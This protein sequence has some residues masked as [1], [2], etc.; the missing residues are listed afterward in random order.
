VQESVKAGADLTLFSGDKLLGGP[1]AGVI[2]GRRALVDDLRRHPLARAVRMDKATI[3]GLN[4][5]LLHYLRG[6]ALE[7][8]PVWRMIAMTLKEIE[9]RAARWTRTVGASTKLI[10]GRSVV[11]GNLPGS[12]P[13][14]LLAIPGRGPPC[15]DSPSPA[16]AT[17]RRRAHRGRPPA[18]DPRTVHPDGCGVAEPSDRPA[19]ERSPRVDPR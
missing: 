4:A 7:K 17:R 6:E 15:R 5:T 12:L 18:L 19:R 3:A 8:V 11:G 16:R 14:K 9:R 2:I 10:D 1:Q 13:T